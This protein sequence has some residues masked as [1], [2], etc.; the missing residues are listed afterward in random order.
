MFNEK[1][2]DGLIYCQANGT[3]GDKFW[4]LSETVLRHPGPNVEQVIGDRPTVYCDC[5]CDK[6]TLRQ[7]NYE[8]F[9]RCVNCNREESVH[10]G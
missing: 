4:H 6:F 10:S 5:G 2:I 7:G 1:V 8:T 3:N 9:A